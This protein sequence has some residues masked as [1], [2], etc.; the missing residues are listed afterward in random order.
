MGLFDCSH[1]AGG[2]RRC[3]SFWWLAHVIGHTAN[4]EGEIVLLCGEAAQDRSIAQAVNR[5]AVLHPPTGIRCFRSNHIPDLHEGATQVRWLFPQEAIYGS[6]VEFHEHHL[7]R[8]PRTQLLRI[9]LLFTYLVCFIAVVGH[10]VGFALDELTPLLSR[11][12][13]GRAQPGRWCR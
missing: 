8:H 7:L 11:K 10:I 5:A 3:G 6:G 4:V 2:G 12:T 9:I 1:I 13:R